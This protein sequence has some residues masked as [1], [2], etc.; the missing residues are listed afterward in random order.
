MEDSGFESAVAEFVKNTPVLYP[1]TNLVAKIISVFHGVAF[2]I[3]SPP[4]NN[5]HSF[6][7]IEKA[8][9]TINHPSH[10]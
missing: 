8:V 2:R 6:V 4:K 3:P 9:K 5:N 7:A 1:D 10:K